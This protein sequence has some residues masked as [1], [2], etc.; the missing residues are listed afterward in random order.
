M[1]WP[2]RNLREYWVLEFLVKSDRLACQILEIRWMGV[3]L[4]SSKGYLKMI[5]WLAL[6]PLSF[7][8]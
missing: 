2:W 3:G 5:G 4:A 8:L 6:S 1:E 7:V